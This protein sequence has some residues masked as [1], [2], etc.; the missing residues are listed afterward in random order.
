MRSYV[1]LFKF[2]AVPNTGSNFRRARQH[3]MGKGVVFPGFFVCLAFVMLKD[4]A[5]WRLFLL[6][7]SEDQYI[8]LGAGRV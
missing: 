8:S 4:A 2:F 7:P 6:L 5:I 1:Q 3:L